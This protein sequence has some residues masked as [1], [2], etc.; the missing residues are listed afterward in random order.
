MTLEQLLNSSADEL[1]KL[2]D[3][4]LE[5]FFAPYFKVTRPELAEKPEQNKPR[6]YTP[7][8]MEEKRKKAIE[9]AK[10]LGIELPL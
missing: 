4:Q 6:T 10:K 2:T 9:M 5:D 7:N 3:K 8:P 1:E